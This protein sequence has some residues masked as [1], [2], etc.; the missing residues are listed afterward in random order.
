MI[1][2]LEVPT[3]VAAARAFGF[4]CWG[5]SALLVGLLV[6]SSAARSVAR[7]DAAQADC[8]LRANLV[9]WAHWSALE[10]CLIERHGWDPD[11]AHHERLRSEIIYLAAH[12]GRP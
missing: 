10:L 6:G 5:A 2:F 8:A 7:A 1:R 4:G 11:A 3:A 12:Q 9:P